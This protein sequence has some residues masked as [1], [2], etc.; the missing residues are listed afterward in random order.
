MKATSKVTR[1]AYSDRINRGKQ[2]ALSEQ[3]RRLGRVRTLVWQ[4]YGSI[5]GAG[6][7]DRQVRDRWLTDGTAKQFGVLANA[8][9]EILRDTIADITANREAAKVLVRRAIARLDV[10]E[11]ERKRLYTALKRDTWTSDRYLSRLM[12]KHWRRGHS[13]VTNQIVVRSDQYTTRTHPASGNVW[14]SIPGIGR[15]SRVRIPLNTNVAPSGTLR[16]ILRGGRVEVHY[17]IDAATMPST[18]PC[19]TGEVG[20]DKGYTEAFVDSHGQQHGQGLNELLSAESD[21]RKHIGQR[22][23]KLRA[24]AQKALANGDQAKHDRI[25][26]NNLGTLKRQRRARRLNQRVRSLCFTAAHQVI[27]HANHVVAE[28]L[29]KPFAARHKLG[30]NANR[31]LNQWTK[32]TLAEALSSVSERRSSALT[33]V[34]AAYTSQVAPCCG[35]LGNR[36]GDRLHC[37]QCGDEWQAD[38]AAAIN[39]LQRYGDPDISLHTPHKRVRQIVQ[40]RDRRPEETAPPGLQ[41]AATASGER[42]IRNQTI[43]DEQS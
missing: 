3:A 9:K 21:H 23:S 2:A 5:A 37:T 42:T 32:G 22:R 27:D 36:A 12:R 26:T 38:H 7:T 24:L 16:L 33:L 14:L 40:Q 43:N 20:V 11:G 39:I 10:S 35:C 28:D 41:P 34:N 13:R 29:T 1:I 4:R 19:G 18:R 8:W 17:Q 25:V 31:R 15:R 30:R 6:V